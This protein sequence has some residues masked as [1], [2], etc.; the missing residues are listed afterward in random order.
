MADQDVTGRN[1]VRAVVGIGPVS[2][3]TTGPSEPFFYSFPD[4]FSISIDENVRVA[5]LSV[6]RIGEVITGAAAFDQSFGGPFAMLS[7]GAAAAERGLFAMARLSALISLSLGV[8]N[9]VPIPVLDGG[10]IIFFIIEAVRG[11]PLSPAMRE[12]VLQIAVLGMVLLMLAV[13]IKD[14]DQWLFS[15]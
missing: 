1:Q 10:Q 9:L 11:R 15:K 2:G 12:R 13:T 8:V 6:E 7:A 3:N 5:K 14:I 4:A